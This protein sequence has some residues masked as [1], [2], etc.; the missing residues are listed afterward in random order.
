MLVKS[1][2]LE[3]RGVA[4]KTSTKSGNV[5][6]VARLESVSS[7]EPFEVYLGDGSRFAALVNGKK[8]ELFNL[9]FDYNSKYK[10]LDL[11]NAERVVNG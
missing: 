3:L 11:V 5:Y 10:Q 9:T 2:K 8:G 1:E 6:K 4:S 7:G